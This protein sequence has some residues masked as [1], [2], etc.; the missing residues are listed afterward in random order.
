MCHWCLYS[1]V[2]LLWKKWTTNMLQRMKHPAL[3]AE[4]SFH[5]LY[6]GLHEKDCMNQI[7]F[8]VS[9]H[10][11]LPGYSFQPRPNIRAHVLGTAV[12]VMTSGLSI[13]E[14]SHTENQFDE[15]KQ[16]DRASLTSRVWRD[17]GSLIFLPYSRKRQKIKEKLFWQLGTRFR[18]SCHCRC[19]EV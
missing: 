19:R 5:L 15:R 2:I 10:W 18:G 7:R 1:A 9:M 6:F 11:M 12:S 17:S 16:E 14:C 13:N 3:L 8:L 4:P